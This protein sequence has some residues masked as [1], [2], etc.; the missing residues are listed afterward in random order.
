MRN[1][2]STIAGVRA[3]WLLA[4]A[5]LLPVPGPSIAA[6][7]PAAAFQSILDKTAAAG[8]PAIVARV[9]T[10]DGAFWTGAAGYATLG[11]K[12]ATPESLFRLFS[13]TKTIVA[14]SAFTLIDEGKLGLDDPIGKWLAPELIANLPYAGELTVRHLIAQ[15]SGIRDYDDEWFDDRVREDMTRVWTP[16]ELVAHAAEGDAIAPPGDGTSYYSNTNYVLL[17]L[18]IEKASGMTLAD[19]IRTRVLEPLGANR[20]F[21]PGAPG[22]SELVTAYYSEGGE[23][24][25][26]SAF[27]PS[28][29]WAAGD[30]AS[31]AKD[32]AK[33]MRGILAGDLLSPESRA[34]MTEDF[35][36]TAGKEIEYGYGTFRAPQ[37]TPAPIGHSGE[38]PGGDAIAMRWPDDGTVIV[39]MT[40][41]ENG[42]HIDALFQIAAVLG[43]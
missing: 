36:P 20:T 14:A 13:I 42:A 9:E 19:A 4:L 34:L 6:D 40:N 10:A 3:A 2:S 8:T 23:L 43:K 39:V 17:G 37:W 38:G 1:H 16:E 15:T 35:R 7:L 26:L 30:L 12:H 22:R 33:L 11:G 18:I 24:I 5:V 28:A 31:T 29:I 21:S 27:D 41:L 25:D 32:A